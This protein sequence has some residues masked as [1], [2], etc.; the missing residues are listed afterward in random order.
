[1]SSVGVLR[2]V[3]VESGEQEYETRM[4]EPC[5]AQP[6]AC[7]E[8]LY[9]FGKR[10]VTKVIRA[11]GQYEELAENRLWPEDDPPLPKGERRAPAKAGGEASESTGTEYLDPLVYAAV[12][13]D[14]A[15][16]VRLG[17]HLYRI[18]GDSGD[19]RASS[20]ERAIGSF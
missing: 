20:N 11:G 1:V 13:V 3:N 16:F 4:G 8:R 19:A 17:T 18:S 15:F 12:A 6:I 7:D 5:W 14:G 9:F 2:C 10:G